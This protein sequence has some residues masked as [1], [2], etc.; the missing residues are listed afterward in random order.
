MVGGAAGAVE[1][2][3]VGAADLVGG[4]GVA[5]AAG[6]EVATAGGAVDGT[7]IATGRVRL[8]MIVGDS[9]LSVL[10][11]SMARAPLAILDEAELR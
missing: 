1:G 2:A 4:A 5:T 7:G 8:P 6:A 10:T 11:T 3:I 9:C